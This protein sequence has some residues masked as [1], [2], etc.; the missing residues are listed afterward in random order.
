MCHTVPQNELDSHHA[1]ALA[2]NLQDTQGERMSSI[3]RYPAPDWDEQP[4][5]VNNEKRKR[6]K[7]TGTYRLKVI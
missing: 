3:L 5:F 7:K 2:A 4:D 6:K 1:P